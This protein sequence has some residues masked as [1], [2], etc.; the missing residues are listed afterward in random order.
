V[1][2]LFSHNPLQTGALRGHQPFPSH[3][4]QPRPY[5][6]DVATPTAP[7][8][9]SPVQRRVETFEQRHLGRVDPF[10]SLG[11]PEPPRLVDLGK[12][13]GAA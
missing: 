11:Q 1:T 13:L 2:T 5:P 10:A 12:L 9:T 8:P 6:I 4:V 7:N 3:A